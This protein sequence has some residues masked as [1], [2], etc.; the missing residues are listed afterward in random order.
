MATKRTSGNV[1]ARL[2]GLMGRARLPED[3][4]RDSEGTLRRILSFVELDWGTSM[5]TPIEDTT[6]TRLRRT[7][8]AAGSISFV[9]ALPIDNTLSH[10]VRNVFERFL[11][12]AG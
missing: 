3:L 7:V 4:V 11:R 5:A 8:F 2:D 1:E 6:P 10:I 9:T 12:P